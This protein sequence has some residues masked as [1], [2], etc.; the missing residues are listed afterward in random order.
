MSYLCSFLVQHWKEHKHKDVY[1]L[2]FLVKICL[3]R[4][5]LDLDKS[6]YRDEHHIFEVLLHNVLEF[7]GHLKWKASFLLTNIIST[8]NTNNNKWL[9]INPLS[10]SILFLPE[11]LCFNRISS[12]IKYSYNC[13]CFHPQAKQYCQNCCRCLKNPFLYNCFLDNKLTATA[14]GLQKLACRI[15]YATLIFFHKVK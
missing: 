11:S 13:W 1:F 6:G 4:T 14:A 9:L 3:D 5:F 8:A 15:N 12:V 10:I 2:S 7:C